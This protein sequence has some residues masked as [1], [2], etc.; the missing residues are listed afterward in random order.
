MLGLVPSL[1]AGTARL[2]ELKINYALEGQGN[3]AIVL[4]HGWACNRTFWNAT[5]PALKAGMRVITLDLPGHGSSSLPPRGAYNA[6]LFANAIAAVMDQTRTKSA[7]LV[8]HS[9]G[10]I[11][12]AHFAHLFPS[13]VDGIVIVDGLLIKPELAPGL[14]KMAEANFA[15][16][17]HAQRE[18]MTRG[19]MNEGLEPELRERIVNEMMTT[20]DEVAGY[21]LMSFSDPDVWK[22]PRLEVPVLAVYQPNKRE[23]E[24]AWLRTVFPHLEYRIFA[25]A[26]HFLM[27]EKSAEFNTLLLDW[28]ARENNRP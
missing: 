10:A 19:M 12:V 28:L 27:M 26:G 9:L 5:V 23:G 14:R 11:V 4:V 16:D 13:R 7:V 15:P 8:G 1:F 24:E 2:G 21:T 20:P 22:L 3:R 17:A 6:D 25:G 18:K